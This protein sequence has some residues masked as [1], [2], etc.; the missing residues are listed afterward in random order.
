MSDQ[1]HRPGKNKLPGG[2]V[3]DAPTPPTQAPPNK[4][5]Q[6]EQSDELTGVPGITAPDMGRRDAPPKPD[7]GTGIPGDARE[8]EKT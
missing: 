2:G 3:P 6:Y 4:P 8:D 1:Q 5:G 7:K